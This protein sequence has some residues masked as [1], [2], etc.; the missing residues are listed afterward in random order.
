M[1]ISWETIV[2]G[3]RGFEKLALEFVEENEPQN[4]CSWKPTK[5][6]RDGNHDAI[7]AR[8]VSDTPKPDFAVFVGYANNVDVWWMEAKY[9]AEAT[10]ENS[11]ISRYR[12]DATIVSAILSRNIS[13]IILLQI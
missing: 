11:I 5:E 1:N 6:T 3:F 13:K 4:G 7:L 2:D 12:L 9:S 8:E 10:Q